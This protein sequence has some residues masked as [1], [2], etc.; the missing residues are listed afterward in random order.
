[1]SDEELR[2]ELVTLLV[3]GHETTATSLAWSLRW[4]LTDDA[5]LARLKDEIRGAEVGGVLV[6]ERVAK[7]E[8]LDATIRET[9]RLVPVIPLVGRVLKRPMRACGYDLPAGTRLMPCIYLAHRR[10]ETFPRPATFDPDR[11]LRDTKPSPS[12]WFPFGGGT[13]RCLGM[14]F[15]LYEMKMMLAAMLSRTTLKLATKGPIRPVRRAITVYPAE[16]LPIVVVRRVPRA[17]AR[18]AGAADAHAP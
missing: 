9:L 2:D 6:P 1:M 3:A 15:A 5:L 14:A 17:S 16:G 11:F 10:P 13:R 8:L 4:I 7:L 12:E 18:K